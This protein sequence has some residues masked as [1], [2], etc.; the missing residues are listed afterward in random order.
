MLSKVNK[1]ELTSNWMLRYENKPRIKKVSQT[2][3]P[4]TLNFNTSAP[5]LA[6]EG[7]N[8]KQKG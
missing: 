7:C 6:L 1:L 5:I 3:A 4:F 2:N 8:Y